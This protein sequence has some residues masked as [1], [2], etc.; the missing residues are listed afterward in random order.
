M[1]IN[2]KTSISP[3]ISFKSNK[4]DLGEVDRIIADNNSHIR[5]LT[6]QKA[7]ELFPDISDEFVKRDIPELLRQEFEP[8]MVLFCAKEST[9]PSGIKILGRTFLER[10]DLYRTGDY[11]N[12]KKLE[13]LLYLGDYCNAEKQLERE[14][15]I[16]EQQAQMPVTERI[17]LTPEQEQK[18]QQIEAEI[19]KLPDSYEYPALSPE[20]KPWWNV[21]GI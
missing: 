16:K 6:Q 13:Q 3:R 11:N 12:P 9:Q 20:K 1:N 7:K 5:F 2:T 18:F 17:S 4:I 10:K 15:K 19:A 8:T 14:A 21:L